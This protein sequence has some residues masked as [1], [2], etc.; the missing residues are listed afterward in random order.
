MVCFVVEKLVLREMLVFMVFLFFV[1][2]KVMIILL[3]VKN[4]VAALNGVTGLKFIL[5]IK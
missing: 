4:V 3:I 2:V 1:Y 5:V